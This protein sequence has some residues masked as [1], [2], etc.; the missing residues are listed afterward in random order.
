VAGGYFLAPLGCAFVGA[1]VFRTSADTQAL[2]AVLS[3]GVGM[4]L[5]AAAA[6][7]WGRRQ[8]KETLDG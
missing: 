2:A 7:A 6:R 4:A 3:L 1:S 8:A 5:A